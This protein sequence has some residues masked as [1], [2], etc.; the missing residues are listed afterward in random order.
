M[1]FWQFYLKCFCYEGGNNLTYFLFNVAKKNAYLRA[2][3]IDK[4]LSHL[5]FMPRVNDIDSPDGCLF[6]EYLEIVQLNP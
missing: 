5:K 2:G 3:A 6:V 4:F 1:P